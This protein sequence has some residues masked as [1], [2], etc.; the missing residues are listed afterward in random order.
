MLRIITLVPNK[1][2]ALEL[3]NSKFADTIAVGYKKFSDKISCLL[4]LNEIIQLNKLAIKN[5]KQLYVYLDAFIYEQDLNELEAILIKLNN[6]GIGGI[7]F[8]DLSIN[9][10]CYEKKLNVNLIYYPQSL[11]TNYDQFDF[12]YENN[13][14]GIV[15]ANELRKSEVFECIKNKNQIK[16]I[17]QVSGYVFMMQ[18]RWNLIYNFANKNKIDINLKDKSFLIKE[19][20]RNFPALIF[21]NKYGTHIYTKYVLSNL[22]FI[23]EFKKANL[24]YIL[25]D[26][27]MHDQSWSIKT[28][29]LYANA[30]CEEK[31]LVQLKRIEKQINKDEIISLGFMSND[32]KDLMYLSDEELEGDQYE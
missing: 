8:N 15:L 27:L 31:D 18:S 2:T 13:V 20:K 4:D 3:V 6:I 28:T 14:Y 32:N 7:I 16:L 11:I 29:E 5:N 19:E 26:G 17:K 1:Q 23:N 9:Q 10:I 30:I 12:Y 24:D 25:I 21:Q 22:D